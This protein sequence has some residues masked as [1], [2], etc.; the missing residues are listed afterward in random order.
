MN[1]VSLLQ[2]TQDRDRIFDRR[3][4]D[5]NLLESTLESLVLFDVFLIFGERR[6]A[7][8]SQ[9][10]ACQCRFEHVRGIDGSFARTCTDK[11]V[12]FVDKKNYLPLGFFD[13]IENGL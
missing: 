2:S 13:L 5:V 4:A 7:D 9:S 8:S 6:S 3:L 10:S 12:Q 1:F 11:R